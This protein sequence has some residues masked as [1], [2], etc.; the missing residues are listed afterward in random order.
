MAIWA[1]GDVQG[2]LGSLL[3]LVEKIDFNPGT[4]RLWFVGDLVNRGPDS[5]GVLR[6]V[7]SLGD[8][9]VTVLGNHDLH[10]LALASGFDRGS[11]DDELDDI[12]R[13]DDRDVLLTW[14]SHCPLAH[15]DDRID[16]LMVHAGVAPTWNRDDVISRSREVEAVV[17]GTESKDF[18]A[19]M[20]GRKPR[21]WRDE[22]AGYDR[23]RFITNCLTR[24]RFLHADGALEFDS[25][26]PPGSQRSG[27]LPWFE[28]PGRQTSAQRIVFGHWSA[29]GRMSREGLVALDSG[30]VWGETLTAARLDCEL[31]FRSVAYAG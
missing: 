31:E 1:I 17:G 26:G 5:L 3:R 28:Y 9:A 8:C 22:L 21:R 10:L 11:A 13:A 14:L 16:C 6:Y 19:S 12:L 30:C 7:H 25:K 29:L 24:T 18:L 27:L 23:L 20:Y 15:Y 2:C 4:D